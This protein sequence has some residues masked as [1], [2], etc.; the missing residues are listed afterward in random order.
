M[1]RSEEDYLAAQPQHEQCAAGHW[2]QVHATFG[3]FCDTCEYE[4]GREADY[5][6]DDNEDWIPPRF[7]LEP[8]DPTDECPF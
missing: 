5:D 2:V 1:F 7:A 6:N 3:M 8:N 4:A